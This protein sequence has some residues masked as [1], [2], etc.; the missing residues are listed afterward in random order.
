MDCASGNVFVR[1]VFCM[2][3]VLFLG[4][5]GDSVVNY[6]VVLPDYERVYDQ[7]QVQDLHLKFTKEDWQVLEDFVEDS[8]DRGFGLDYVYTKAQIKFAGEVRD[9]IG[10]RYKGNSSYSRDLA[11]KSLKIHLE[12]YVEN[13]LLFGLKKINLN[14]SAHDRSLMRECLSYEVFARAG[15][16]AS[17]CSFV[18]LYLDI[19][20]GQGSQLKGVFVNVEQVDKAYL[21]DRFDLADSV[22]NLYKP[23]RGRGSCPD[24]ACWG[25]NA[26]E[27]M[28]KRTNKDEAD[29]SDLQRLIEILGQ[30]Y[31]N[32][33]TDGDQ[34]LSVLPNIFDVDSFLRYLAVGNIL[35]NWDS[36]TAM[37]HNYY[38]YNHP[39]NPV[40]EGEDYWQ[41]IPWDLNESFGNFK[42]REVMGSPDSVIKWKWCSPAAATEETLPLLVHLVMTV[43][44]WRDQYR[45]YMIEFTAENG[46][47]S[48]GFI[49]FRAD[50]LLDLIE[51]VI[52]K[53]PNLKCPLNQ[54]DCFEESVDRSIMLYIEQRI[55]FLQDD[56]LVAYD[57]DDHENGCHWRRTG[58]LTAT[59]EI[60]GPPPG[61]GPPP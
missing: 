42:A 29:F 31:N 11:R 58:E 41:L 10:V 19:D 34:V 44:E 35:G 46:A 5:A 50:E 36:Y 32:G 2:V 52:A 55:E 59:K 39:L 6:Q 38:I 33:D 28:Q 12:E 15:L 8:G 20:D 40:A 53:D 1:F 47:A 9:S 24:L 30:L 23:E 60:G 56:L 57:Y 61:G 21:R 4:C 49:T 43:P 17:R 48:N 14:N 18:N 25:E 26:E 22:G 3:S 51:P 16:P 54:P 45:Q 13:N 7:S 27:L 37:M